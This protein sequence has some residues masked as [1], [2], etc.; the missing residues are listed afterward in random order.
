MRW[1][2][3]VQLVE[4]VAEALGQLREEL[5]LVGGCAV[6][7]LITDEARPAI[8]Q[9]VDVDLVAEVTTLTSYYKIEEKLRDRGF[10]ELSEVICRWTKDGLIVDVMPP[11]E[12]GHN[13][14]NP[15][16]A[17][18]VENSKRISLPSGVEIR[19]VSA[20]FFLATKLVSF[21]NRGEGDYGHHDI[22]DIVNIVDGRKEL[23]GEVA[24][25]REDVKQFIMDEID[26][27]LADEQF[28]EQI[29]W[30]LHPDETNQARTS[31]IIG[32]LRI[33]AGL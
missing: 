20:P 7:L 13:F 19:I 26:N 15:W 30:H 28:T 17:A 27:L 3:N 23:L 2:P 11:V 6:G 22:E 16:Y 32:R 4:L 29:P 25:S 31:V 9:T 33:L 5:V 12:L 24:S 1:D 18:A 10:K 8:R 21:A 14:M